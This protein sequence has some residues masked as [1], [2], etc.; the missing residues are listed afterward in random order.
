MDVSVKR[1]TTQPITI[2]LKGVDLRTADWVIV[3]IK[4]DSGPLIEFA[5][6][7]MSLSSDGSK[8]IIVVQLSEMQSVS[9]ISTMVTIDCNWMMNG[10]RSG[11][12]ESTIKIEPTLLTRVVGNDE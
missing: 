11:A 1:G 12:K 3:S 2:T 6:N 9:L 4:S 8:T 10:I 7:E 5:R